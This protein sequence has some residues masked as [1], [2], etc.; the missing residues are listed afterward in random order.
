MNILTTWS[1]FLNVADREQVA[2]LQPQVADLHERIDRFAR[3]EIVPAMDARAQKHL[4]GAAEGMLMYRRRAL[5]PKIDVY[6]KLRRRIDRHRWVAEIG[7]D[8]A[9]SGK[10]RLAQRPLEH[11]PC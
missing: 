11:V 10:L 4:K 1:N 8:V 6:M 3:I 2:E 7:V 9:L 5:E